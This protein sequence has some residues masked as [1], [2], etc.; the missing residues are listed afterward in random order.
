MILCRVLIR[1][2]RQ[3]LQSLSMGGLSTGGGVVVV[4]VVVVVVTLVVLVD[5]VVAAVVVVVGVVGEKTMELIQLK[6]SPCRGRTFLPGDPKQKAAQQTI[7]MNC[8]FIS[9]RC[10][11]ATK[12]AT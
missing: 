11:F 5:V 6:R 12:A 7:R 3:V 9:P 2:Q 10:H 4:V 1:P 8:S